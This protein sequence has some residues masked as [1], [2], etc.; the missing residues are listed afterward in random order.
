[1]TFS[2]CRKPRA[3]IEDRIASKREREAKALAF[4]L[5]VLTRDENHC[6]ACHRLVRRTQEAVA[7]RAEVHHRRGR[8]VAPEDRYNVKA[9]VTLCLRCH[10]DPEVIAKFRK[11]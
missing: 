8:N 11:P 5:A 9:A 2:P 4:R 10:K 3:I 7:E 6:R 1:M